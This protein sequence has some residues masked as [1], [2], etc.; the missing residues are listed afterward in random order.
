M[1]KMPG[2]C[3]VKNHKVET[4]NRVFQK[5]RFCL[6]CDPGRYFDEEDIAIMIHVENLSKFYGAIP[7][8]TR[9]HF[10]FN[11]ARLPDFSMRMALEKRPQCNFDW[12]YA[13]PEAAKR[14]SQDLMYLINPCE[15]VR[16]RIGY[17]PEDL[18]RLYRD[19]NVNAF[20]TFAAGSKVLKK[21]NVPH[22]SL[23]R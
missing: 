16:K 7:V 5:T 14:R 4:Q 8:F 6:Q 21:N 15:E 23:P 2:T 13:V 9:Y 18:C 12:I 19:M 1:L 17:L 20:Y 11:R 22:R 10:P 3:F